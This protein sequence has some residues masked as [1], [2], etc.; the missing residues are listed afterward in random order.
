MTTDSGTGAGRATAT[1]G[2]ARLARGDIDDDLVEEVVAE[3]RR[4]RRPVSLPGLCNHLWFDR[5]RAGG[6]DG[7]AFSQLLCDVPTFAHGVVDGEAVVNPQAAVPVGAVVTVDTGNDIAY[8]E[9]VWKEGAHPLLD[10]NWVPGW[11]AGAPSGAPIGPTPPPADFVAP[12]GR[13]VLRE[14]LV[15]D[16]T[17]LGAALAPPETKIARLRSRGRRLDQLG[18]LVA[19]V[20]Y[21]DGLDEADE[22]SFWAAWTAAHQ[23]R[24]LAASGV[25][26]SGA[27]LGEAAS[28]LAAAL[29]ERDDVRS[30]GPFYV[31][32]EV[33][34]DLMHAD[35]ADDGGLRRTVRGLARVASHDRVG[36]ASMSARLVDTCAPDAL[37]GCAWPTAVVCASLLALDTLMG[38]APDGDWHGT[39]LRLDDAWQGGGLWR[40]E[41]LEHTFPVDADPAVALGLGWV[42][43]TGGEI[44]RVVLGG[45]E[46]VDAPEWFEDGESDLEWVLTGSEATWAVHLSAADIDTDRL[47]LPAQ[48]SATLAETL[49]TLGQDL[50]LLVLRHDGQAE[51]RVWVRLGDDGNVEVPW[52][53][54]I[55]PGTTVRLSWQV[56]T[57]VLNAATTLLATP[58][59][60][61][62]ITYTH[63]FNL[64]LALAAAGATETGS[65]TV[66]VRQLVRAAVRRHGEVTEDGCMALGIDAV[67]ERCFGP[68]GEVVPGYGRSVLRKAVVAAVAGMATT[69]MARLDGDLVVVSPRLTEAGRR[70]DTELLARFVDA[71]RQRLRRHAQRHW[72]LPT[73]VNLPESWRRSE[74]KD[75]EWG[76]VAGTDGLPDTDLAAN[77]TWRKG[78]VR[79]SG[80]PAEV[81]AALDRAKRSMARLGAA[82]TAPDLD[83]LL[84]DPYAPEVTAP[85]SGADDATTAAP[86]ATRRPGA[87]R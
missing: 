36:W 31:T 7:A 11:L 47:R 1:S 73:I 19:D 46:A 67:V 10:A 13:R 52:P 64:A 29:D 79:G 82:A 48:V 78:H 84:D 55:L 26:V 53:L 4:R 9:V 23:P 57:T 39:H 27:A 33:Y 3:L 8:G 21:I 85:A 45:P 77:Q 20:F 50:A 72:V 12:L 28:V 41:R 75:S 34:R 2:L 66:T 32:A 69:G 56:A 51:Q 6:Y 15:V 43:H 14:R 70:A 83:A 65:R 16:F 30:F 25:P 71:T 22:V 63:V 49:Y 42:A 37:L 76:Q 59:E 17:C 40:A 60:V 54:G 5:G 61:A 86:S 35:D 80:M 68:G 24:A 62:G 58:E 81:T 44:E 18:H 38:E 87:L 74:A